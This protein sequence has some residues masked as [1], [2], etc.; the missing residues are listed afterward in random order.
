[1]IAG[2]LAVLTVIVLGLGLHFD[3]PVILST[4]NEVLLAFFSPSF[5]VTMY[6]MDYKVFN[7][8]FDFSLIVSWSIIIA[9]QYF[10]GYMILSIFQWIRAYR[11]RKVLR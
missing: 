5:S 8:I 7:Q 10:Y 3:G 4:T 11:K 2:A 6:L 1:L 9:I